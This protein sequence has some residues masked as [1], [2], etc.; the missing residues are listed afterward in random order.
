MPRKQAHGAASKQRVTR[1][2]R[3]TPQNFSES[4]LYYADRR[5]TCAPNNTRI[6][7]WTRLSCWAAR[8][9]GRAAGGAPAA[10]RA[11]VL[12]AELGDTVLQ[13]LVSS[14]RV[15]GPGDGIVAKLG[16]SL[17]DPPPSN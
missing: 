10:E 17:P 2:D 16:L 1:R 5:P 11:V 7:V 4:M 13:I 9:S 14:G 6:R 15:F 12:K 3:L 8:R